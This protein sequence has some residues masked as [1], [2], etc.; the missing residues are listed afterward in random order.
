LFE[1]LSQLRHGGEITMYSKDSI[2]LVDCTS[3]DIGCPIFRNRNF[4]NKTNFNTELEAVWK[5]YKREITGM[6]FLMYF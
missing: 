3:V 2:W 6:I 5:L 4:T 1:N